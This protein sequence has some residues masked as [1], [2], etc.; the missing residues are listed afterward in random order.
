VHVLGESGG[1]VSRVVELLGDPAIKKQIVVANPSKYLSGGPMHCFNVS[2]GQH[3]QAWYY[4][5][6]DAG[7]WVIFAGDRIQCI[8]F[9]PTQAPLF[10]ESRPNNS[11]KPN[12]HRGGA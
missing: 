12:P 5:I 1:T 2:R 3:L 7:Y 8:A 6:E 11:F 10:H 9:E 4:P